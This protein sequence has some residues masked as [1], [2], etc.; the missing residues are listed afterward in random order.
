MTIAVAPKATLSF[1]MPEVQKTTEGTN[2]NAILDASRD[3]GNTES[4][5]ITKRYEHQKE[6]NAN[7]SDDN[8]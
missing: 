8:Q 1:M 3:E 4:S 2:S 7:Q 5:L 6:K